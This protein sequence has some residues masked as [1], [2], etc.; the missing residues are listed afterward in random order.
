MSIWKKTKTLP[1]AK[2]LTAIDRDDLFTQQTTN[3]YTSDS[4]S[5]AYTG[6]DNAQAGAVYAQLADLNA[7]R[8]AY[9]NLRA[10]YDDLLAKLKTA[11][12][13]S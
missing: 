10:S 5:V 3:A 12:L 9:D 8:V 11:V 1:V 2:N 4:E 7:L 13:I 6:I